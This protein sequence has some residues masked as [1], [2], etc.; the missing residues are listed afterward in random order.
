MSRFAGSS[1]D[2]PE[3]YRKEQVD[4]PHFPPSNPSYPQSVIYSLPP[5]ADVSEY[6]RQAQSRLIKQR[7]PILPIGLIAERAP[8]SL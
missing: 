1:C 7:S 3:S 4:S 6:H 8:P 2:R 5:A